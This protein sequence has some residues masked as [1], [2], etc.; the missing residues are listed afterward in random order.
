MVIF[1]CYDQYFYILRNLL[2]PYGVSLVGGDTTPMKLE[3]NHI[4]H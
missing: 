2:S 3:L 1:S 4:R